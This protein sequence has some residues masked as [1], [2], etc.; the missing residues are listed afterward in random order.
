MNK[1]AFSCVI[2]G[3]ALKK[4]RKH[5][6]SCHNKECNVN[7]LMI[8]IVETKRGHSRLVN[9]VLKSF[10]KEWPE[11]VLKSFLSS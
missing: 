7:E 6:Y 8:K 10:S 5:F 11:V 1:N 3:S 4:E 2:C 9:F